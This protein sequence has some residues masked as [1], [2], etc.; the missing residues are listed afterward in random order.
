MV[1]PPHPYFLLTPRPPVTLHYD[2]VRNDA[3]SAALYVDDL[4]KGSELVE[5]QAG[6][7]LGARSRLAARVA[8]P[9]IPPSPNCC[10]GARSRIARQGKPR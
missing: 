1:R 9:P 3:F 5:R 7:A 4:V 2:R 6:A 10:K 8:V